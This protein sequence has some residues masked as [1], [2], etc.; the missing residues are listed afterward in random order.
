MVNLFRLDSGAEWRWSEI[1]RSNFERQYTPEQSLLIAEH[2][3]NQ[4]ELSIEMKA[5]GEKLQSY[6]CK[7]TDAKSK[8][9]FYGCGKG[10]GLQSKASAIYEALEHYATH[11]FC[12]RYGA[13]EKNYLSIIDRICAC[14]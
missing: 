13:D 1:M 5:A 2:T 8:N 12:Q 10:L 11:A 9:I 4:W 6:H 7:L 3:L 14:R